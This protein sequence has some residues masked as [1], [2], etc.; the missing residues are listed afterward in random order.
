VRTKQANVIL[1][2]RVAVK[3]RELK[4]SK[5]TVADVRVTNTLGGWNTMN[6]KLETLKTV[7]WTSLA[8]VTAYIV[9]NVLVGVFYLSLLM[10]YGGD[11]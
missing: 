7:G 4:A 5:T 9:F 10:I 1:D 2:A 8:L 6:K 3:S 11:R